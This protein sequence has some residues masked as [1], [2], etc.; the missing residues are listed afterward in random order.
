MLLYSSRVYFQLS[1]PCSPNSQ[2]RH[3]TTTGLSFYENVKSLTVLPRKNDL[4]FQIS[5]FYRAFENEPQELVGSLAYLRGLSA[6]LCV[7][8][9]PG[10][11]EGTTIS[12][13][14]FQ[15]GK[16][17]CVSCSGLMVSRAYILLQEDDFQT[18]V[19][20]RFCFVTDL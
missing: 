1:Q 18:R 12:T 7:H 20:G 15:G 5:G 19:W 9:L 6:W 14:L 10:G 4:E 17:F 8:I 3:A 2:M 16:I 11:Q 13:T